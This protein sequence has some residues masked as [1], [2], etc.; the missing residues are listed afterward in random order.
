MSKW[1]KFQGAKQK[2]LDR[3]YEKQTT[4]MIEQL[5]TEY[6]RAYNQIKMELYEMWEENLEIIAEQNTGYTFSRLR[7][8]QDL[9]KQIELI[10]QELAEV[11]KEII[12]NGMKQAYVSDYIDLGKLNEKYFVM[13]LNTSLPQF[14]QLNGVQLL[15]SYIKSPV[16]TNTMEIAK[17]LELGWFYDGTAGRWFNARID[18]RCKKLNYKLGETLRIEMIKQTPKAQIADKL[19]HDLDISFNSAKTL[20]RTETATMENQAVVHNCYK[21]GFNSVRFVTMHDDRVCDVCKGMEGKIFPV[22]SVTGSDMVMHPNCRCVLQECIVD[23]DTNT[24]TV[25]DDIIVMYDSNGKGYTRKQLSDMYN[26]LNSKD[27]LKDLRDE[28]AKEFKAR[29]VEYKRKEYKKKK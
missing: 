27:S 7:E 19:A 15:E 29:G 24:P 1:L 11:E 20:I 14:N 8:L 2:V 16:P 22:D 13:D 12:E 21:L 28:M 9:K 5:K 6:Q 23:E 10:L 25:E 17:Q 4:N 18:E 3:N 26:E